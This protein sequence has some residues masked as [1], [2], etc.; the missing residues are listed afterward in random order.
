MNSSLSAVVTPR[1]IRKHNWRCLGRIF[2]LGLGVGAVFL[3]VFLFVWLLASIL[4]GDRALTWPVVIGS[5]VFG[6]AFLMAGRAHLRVSGPLDWERIARMPMKT[7][8]MRISTR[9]NFEYAQ[10]GEGF[11]SMLLA[12]SGWIDKI[13]FEWNSLIPVREEIAERLEAL[14]RN[15]AARDSWMPVKDF[16]RHEEDLFLLAK[17]EILA[18]RENVGQ[19]FF[20]V[21]LEGTA[22]SI[23]RAADDGAQSEREEVEV[24]IVS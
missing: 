11:F 22:R 20:H 10:A 17:L 15:L 5:S 4:T 16:E 14:R 6:M 19:W 3:I 18:I 24:D 13:V 7:A 1:R 23:L 9:R 12:G 2:L 21:T 8:G